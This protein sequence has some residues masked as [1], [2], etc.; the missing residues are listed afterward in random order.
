MRN[1]L[2][3]ETFISWKT[4]SSEEVNETAFTQIDCNRL[5]R[6][7]VFCYHVTALFYHRRKGV[8]Q[9]EKS[10]SFGLVTR[11]SKKI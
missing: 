8:L 6:H 7:T 5:C 4:L 1:D 11:K 10:K 3:F 9:T 2:T